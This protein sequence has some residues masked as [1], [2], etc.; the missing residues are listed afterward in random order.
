MSTNRAMSCG[1]GRAARGAI[2]GLALCLSAIA[3]CS[4]SNDRNDIGAGYAGLEPGVVLHGLEPTA[5]A[6]ESPTGAGDPNPDALA[7]AD[8]RP[9]L[10]L[11]RSG[12]EPR[13]F[14]VPVSATASG[15]DYA[16][17]HSMIDAAARDRGQYPTPTSALELS[18]NSY[19]DVAG[20]AWASMP[21]AVYDMLLMPYRAIRA[22][23]PGWRQPEQ[24]GPGEAYT[25]APAWTARGVPSGATRANELPAAAP[26]DGVPAGHTPNPLD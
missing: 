20:D 25:R 9:V 3:G 19:W 18:P 11:G 1:S 12:W 15:P 16:E 7:A 8:G 10:D 14:L 6:L 22:A 17:R 21:L 24:R 2:A 26:G 13:L 23:G 4:Y 5:A